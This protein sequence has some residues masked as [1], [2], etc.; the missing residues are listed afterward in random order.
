MTTAGDI[1]NAMLQACGDG[2]RAT[3]PA[4]EVRGHP[5]PVHGSR[6]ELDDAPF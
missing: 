6:S 1:A 2:F 3:G 5:A 4:K